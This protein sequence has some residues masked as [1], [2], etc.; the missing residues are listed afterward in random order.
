LETNEIEHIEEANFKVFYEGFR[1]KMKIA[2]MSVVL[3]IE[4]ASKEALT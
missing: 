3:F 4:G 1:Q 2:E